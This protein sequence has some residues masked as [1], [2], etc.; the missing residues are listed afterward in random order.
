MLSTCGI[1]SPTTTL[2]TGRL[3]SGESLQRL[4]PRP[5]GSTTMAGGTLPDLIAASSRGTKVLAPSRL[6][7]APR[8]QPVNHR[9]PFLRRAFV[10]GWQVDQVT[11]LTLDGPAEERSI[12]G[13]GRRSKV[14]IDPSQLQRPPR[15]DS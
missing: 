10:I 5:F 1:S 12:L 6:R 13:A 11:D 3:P 4:T 2:S 8:V 7:P 14:R 9:I 15:R